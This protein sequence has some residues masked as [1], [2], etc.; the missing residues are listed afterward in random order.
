[1]DGKDKIES[2]PGLSSG[3][4]PALQ[5]LHGKN[6][7]QAEI[8]R[9]YIQIIRDIVKEPMFLLLLVACTLY[10]IPGEKGEGLLMLLAMFFVSAISLYQEVKSTNAVKALQ[11]FTQPQV[12]VI[13]DSKETIIPS[14]ELVPGDFMLLEEGM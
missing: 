6:I 10:F 7:Y 8:S 12:T 5:Q 2:I 4:I 3:E 13:R 14:A 11:Q 1:M 9:R